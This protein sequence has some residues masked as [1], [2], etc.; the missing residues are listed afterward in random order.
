[1]GRY[2]DIE[3]LAWDSHQQKSQQR[4]NVVCNSGQE[5]A[6]RTLERVAFKASVYSD[7]LIIETYALRHAPNITTIQS[8]TNP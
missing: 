3:N 1:M 8:V 2:G 4:L 7:I 6:W 5:R